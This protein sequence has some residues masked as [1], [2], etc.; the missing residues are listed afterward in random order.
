MHSAAQVNVLSNT[1][2]GNDYGYNPTEITE[3]MLC[4]NVVGGGKDACQETST[5]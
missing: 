2:C 3:Q 4:A 5:S 1:A